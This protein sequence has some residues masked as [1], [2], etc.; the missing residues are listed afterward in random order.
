MKGGGWP[1][2]ND[3]KVL[4]AFVG[5]EDLKGFLCAESIFSSGDNCRWSDDYHVHMPGLKK[6]FPFP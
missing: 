6:M 2:R 3:G 1:F 4:L 5:V